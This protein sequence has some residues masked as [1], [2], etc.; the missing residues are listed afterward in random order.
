M[1]F[2]SIH[3]DFVNPSGSGWVSFF[4]MKKLSAVIFALAAVL[5]AGQASARSLEVEV[6]SGLVVPGYN[7]IR[8][9]GD[10]GTK[11]SLVDDLKADN[12]LY[13][14]A[15]LTWHISDRHLVSALVAPLRV[16]ASGTFDRPVF[17]E[18]RV[19]EPGREVSA[20]FRFDSYRLTWR[21]RIYESE[22]LKLGLGLTA[23]IRDAEIR[24]EDASG[25]A[26]NTNTGLVP[27][28]NFALEWDLG[29]RMDL[30]LRGDALA[31][32]QG[33]AEDVLASL[34]YRIA[35]GLSVRAGYRI[36]EGG[37]DNDE[38]YTFALFHYFS[39]G[40]TVSI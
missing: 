28:I 7:D 38:V 11:F 14:R 39:F 27:L 22:R 12:E 23:K 21:Y 25:V 26:R 16:D 32:P 6:E 29:R 37:A 31:A 34:R 10:T 9:P 5:I 18:D 1:I 35:D 4:N 36:L 15:R 8:I 3:D 17:Y 20:R 19:F 33:R 30:L 13:V 2:P 24:L 40:I